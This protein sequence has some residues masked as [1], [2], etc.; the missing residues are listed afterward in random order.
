MKTMWTLFKRDEPQNGQQSYIGG[1]PS[2]PMGTTLP[3][4]KLCG[5]TETF[6]F[7]VAF[8]S[9]AA[10]G[11]RTLSCFACMRCADERF[12]IPEMLDDHRQGCDI[13]AGFLMSYQRNFAFL[14][15][16]TS[17]ARIVKNYDEQVAFVSL[18]LQRGSDSGGFGRIGG[19]PNWVLEDEGPAT[20]GSKIPMVFVLELM[21]GIHFS[22]VD[23]AL[24]QMEID[25]FGNPSPSPL[26]YYQLFLGNATFL[27]GTSSGVPLVYAITQV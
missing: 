17:D 24:P 20:Y 6:M 10:W 21:A 11:G 13:P 16:P 19:A 2:L 18:E 9:E 5:H 4:C 15:F 12:L 26:Q 23:G 1:K 3:V 25:I 8:P 14:A 22:N 27:F 7:Q